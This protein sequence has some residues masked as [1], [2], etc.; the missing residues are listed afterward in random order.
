LE[1][2]CKWADLNGRL[3]DEKLQRLLYAFEKGVIDGIEEEKRRVVE[4]L[5][6]Y[7]EDLL[8]AKNGDI[9]KTKDPVY[10]LSAQW[11][12]NWCSYV[13]A[14]PQL[15]AGVEV[16]EWD[17]MLTDCTIIMLTLFVHLVH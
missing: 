3:G 8:G 12:A 17:G 6:Q 9:E 5:S 11:W 10:L 14:P 16:G 13:Q 2:F 4:G 15:R 7:V 1:A